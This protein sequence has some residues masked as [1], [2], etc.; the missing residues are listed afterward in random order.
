M[1]E[2]LAPK[3]FLLGTP[4]SG[5]TSFFESFNRSREIIT[6]LPD[7]TEADW[8]A[9]EPWVFANGFQDENKLWWLEHYPKCDQT[10]TMVAVDCT[11][12]YFGDQAAPWAIS[13]TFGANRG[14]IVFMVFLRDPVERSHSHYY[15]YLDNDVL[16]G[17]Y[18]E[19][20]KS[21]FPASFSKAVEKLIKH[22]AMC[23]CDCDDVF[24]DSMY[25]DSFRRYFKNFHSSAFHVVP[26]EFAVT[27]DIVEY[28]WKLLNVAKGKGASENM[29]G[30]GNARNHH[31]YPSL[32]EDIPSSTLRNKFLA[33]MGKA[34]GSKAVAKVLV[35]S[36][37][38]L[39]KYPGKMNSVEGIAKWL[40][41]HW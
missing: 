32:E 21:L 5:T 8:H 15:Q 26:F 12:G 3:F 34:T 6:Y 27:S 2:H 19:C 25:A 36:A 28:A 7:S 37:A 38:H 13:R 35:D 29:V 16:K 11:P 24:L 40:S 18:N 22:G 31:E 23:D 14:E 30:G 20:P 39:Y 33:W 1:M 17:A 41:D 4:K 10:K 9:K